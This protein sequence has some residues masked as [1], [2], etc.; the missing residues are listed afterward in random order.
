MK[1]INEFLSDKNSLF[2]ESVV[3]ESVVDPVSGWLTVGAFMATASL[4]FALLT[5]LYNKMTPEPFHETSW[6]DDIKNWWKD[7]K[8]NKII[9]RIS[10]DP[11]VKEFLSDYND[12]KSGW[13]KL[14][15][16]KLSEEELKYLRSITKNKVREKINK[17]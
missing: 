3:E 17:S 7:K 9:K 16:T 10:E 4:L 1:S 2:K 8:A 6:L 11:E 15:K 14:L 13:R 12:N 5:S